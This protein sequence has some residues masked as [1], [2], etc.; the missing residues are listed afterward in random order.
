MISQE[1]G[2]YQWVP[3]IFALQAVFFYL[4]V[5]LWR[6]LYSSLG[7][8][9]GTICDTC[10]IRSNMIARDRL[11]NLEKVASFLTYER[12]IHSSLDDRR[13]RHLSSGRFLISAYLF[14]KFCYALNAVVQFWII[15]KFLGVESIW[16]GA[17]VFTDL[18][19][20]LEWP[21]TGNF[22]RVTLCDFT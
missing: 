6:T 13:H 11:K 12:E 20:G 7:I 18:I 3:F 8:K 17:Q 10:N 2:Y 5:I 21:Q 4:P 9:V 1:N 14:M 22:P 15:K 16:W 19:H